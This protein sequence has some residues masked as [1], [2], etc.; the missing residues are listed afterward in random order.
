MCKFASYRAA[1]T[2]TKSFEVMSEPGAT[3]GR[4]RDFR[5]KEMGGDEMA[6]N[7]RDFTAFE[8]A[9]HDR[10]AGEYA[11]NFAP[12]TTLALDA[13]LDAACVAPGRRA[14]VVR[15]GRCSSRNALSRGGG[16]GR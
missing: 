9:A 12:L 14:P 13:L 2:P 1:A 8:R 4:A 10:I 5:A 6:V 16:R 11:E 7:A 15:A 3:D